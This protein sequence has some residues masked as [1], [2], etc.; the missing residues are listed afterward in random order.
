MCPYT[1]NYLPQDGFGLKLFSLNVVKLI[2]IPVFGYVSKRREGKCDGLYM[3]G[4]GS[5]TIRRCGLVVVGVSLWARALI[6]LS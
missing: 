1:G 2:Y 3:L 4:Q 5:G 6:P